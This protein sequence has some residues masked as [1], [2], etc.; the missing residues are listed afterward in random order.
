MLTRSL[1]LKLLSAAIVFGAWQIAAGMIPVSYAF[2]TFMES[3][4]ALVA[5]DI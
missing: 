2:P 5:H 1:F 4:D 3:M